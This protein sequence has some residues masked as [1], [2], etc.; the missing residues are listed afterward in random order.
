MTFS[1]ADSM[2]F[3][4][5]KPDVLLPLFLEIA[6][7][8]H[9]KSNDPCRIDLNFIPAIGICSLDMSYPTN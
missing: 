4:D 3:K 6:V 8:G 1:V 5:P 9:D 7:Q 2:D